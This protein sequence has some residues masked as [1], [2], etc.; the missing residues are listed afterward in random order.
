MVEFRRLFAY[1]LCDTGR[2]SLTECATIKRLAE[3]VE[4]DVLTPYLMIAIAALHGHNRS[5]EDKTG[6]SLWEFL[7]RSYQRAART[8]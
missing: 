2:L 4:K 3:G 6:T 5:D 1:V 8:S 7:A